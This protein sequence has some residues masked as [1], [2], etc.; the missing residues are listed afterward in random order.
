M[1]FIGHGSQFKAYR[2]GIF[3]FLG[4]VQRVIFIPFQTLWYQ[5]LFFFL[6]F[7]GLT[8]AFWSFM[9]GDVL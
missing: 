6:M 7:I 5:S 1:R 3:G 2:T 9:I 8:R 4:P